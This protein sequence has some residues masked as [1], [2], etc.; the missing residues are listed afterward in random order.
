MSY[1]P[2]GVALKK[3]VVLAR[4]ENFHKSAAT[5]TSYTVF[6]KFSTREAARYFKKERVRAARS[7]VEPAVI[8]DLANGTVVR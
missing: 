7:R 1:K 4:G 6:R 8:I 5:A 2:W 3:N